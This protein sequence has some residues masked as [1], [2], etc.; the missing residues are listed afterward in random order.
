M[1]M[2]ND[3]VKLFNNEDEASVVVKDLVNEGKA[4]GTKVE[5]LLKIQ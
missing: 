5:I 3:R 1:E 2:S 4:T